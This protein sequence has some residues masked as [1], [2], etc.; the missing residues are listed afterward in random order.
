MC[1]V[2][3]VVRVDVN[4]QDMDLDQCATGDSWFADTHQCNRT[5]MEV[6][7]LHWILFFTYCQKLQ[8]RIDRRRTDCDCGHMTE[9]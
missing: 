1:V 4:V 7:D 2:R 5:T 9:M 3:G 6:R 8:L